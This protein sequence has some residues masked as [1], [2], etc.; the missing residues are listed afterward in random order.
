M[1]LLSSQGQ[2]TVSLPLLLLHPHLGVREAEC[3]W[4]HF[5]RLFPLMEPVP[6]PIVAPALA[7]LLHHIGLQLLP[8]I[9]RP[10]CSHAVSAHPDPFRLKGDCELTPV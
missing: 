3:S 4:I 2:P 10:I 7:F 8:F 5:R 9:H 6:V 1:R